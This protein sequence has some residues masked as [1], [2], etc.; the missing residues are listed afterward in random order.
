M[1]PPRERC[2]AEKSNRQSPQSEQEVNLKEIMSQGRG[3]TLGRTHGFPQDVWLGWNAPQLDPKS[4]AMLAALGVTRSA[5]H[6][7]FISAPSGAGGKTTCILAL[8]DYEEGPF[9]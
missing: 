1:C 3:G 6:R 8:C 7:P 4:T 2:L 9:K 5:L